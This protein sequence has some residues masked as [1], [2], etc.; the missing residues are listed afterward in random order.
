MFSI[1]AEVALQVRDNPVMCR[2]VAS[3]PLG[4]AYAVSVYVRT[5]YGASGVL[6]LAVTTRRDLEAH[7]AS[8]CSLRT[9]EISEDKTTVAA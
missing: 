3:Q 8:L 2:P 7:A 5:A 6:A 9:S 1:D 4:S